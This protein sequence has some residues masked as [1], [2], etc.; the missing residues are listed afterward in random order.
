MRTFHYWDDRGNI[1]CS[2]HVPRTR[3][4]GPLADGFVRMS[5]DD[6]RALRA[7]WR[8]AGLS[9]NEIFCGVCAGFGYIAEAS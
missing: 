6:E 8:E 1:L 4:R 3:L 5:V 7:D 9:D 2:I